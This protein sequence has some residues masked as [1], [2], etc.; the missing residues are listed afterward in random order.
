MGALQE[1]GRLA[2]WKLLRKYSRASISGL[3]GGQRG[4]G[5]SPG[6]PFRAISQDH[7]IANGK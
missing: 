6:G 5:G 3:A 2:P 7:Y 1:R 4:A